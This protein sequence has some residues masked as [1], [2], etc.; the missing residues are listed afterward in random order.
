ARPQLGAAVM[1]VAVSLRGA[2][3]DRN[4]RMVWRDVDLDVSAG[5]FVAILGP[6]GVGKSTLLHA[7]LGVVPLKAGTITVLGERA[8]RGNRAIGYLPQRRGFDPTLRIRGVDVV[9][10]GVDGDRWGVPLSRT[11]SREARARVEE[12][13][14]LVGAESYAT[15]PIGECSGGE[16][17]RL[18]IAQ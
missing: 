2:R 8:G 18:L 16:Q 11:R 5:E 9:R 13:V 7:I 17:Q 12:L 3:A 15:K 6:N 1:T 10:L 14:Q 4:H